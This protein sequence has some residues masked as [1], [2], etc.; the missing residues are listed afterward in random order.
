MTK[1]YPFPAEGKI[2]K[3]A[4]LSSVMNRF[5]NFENLMFI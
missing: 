2:K 4:M 5:Y 1:I 3:A